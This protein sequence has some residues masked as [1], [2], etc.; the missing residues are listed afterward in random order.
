MRRA[1]TICAVAL[2]MSP[3][4]AAAEDRPTQGGLWSFDESDVVE[5]WEEP[6]QTVRVHYSVMGPNVTRLEDDDDDGVPDYAQD[7]A[8]RT[9]ESIA[10]FT[11]LGFRPPVPESAIETELGGSPAYD[12]YLVDFGGAADGRFGIDGCGN[13]GCAGFYVVENDFAGYGYATVEEGITTVTSHESFHGVQAAYNFL[14]N[15]VS[16]GTATWAERQFD[17]ESADFVRLCNG[18]LADTGRPV[19][20]PPGGPVPL[21]AYGTALWFDFLT[22]RHDVG[23]MV[24]FFEAIADDE[25]AAAPELLFES[26]LAARDDDLERSWATFAQ[27]NLAT[28]PRAGV[29]QSHP[30]ASALDGIEADA[31]GSE[32]AL[33]ARFYPLAASYFNLQHPGGDLWFVTDDVLEDVVFSL[34]PVGDFRPD[35]A[36]GDPIATWTSDDAGSQRI[37]EAL[38]EGG[39]WIVGTL[40]VVADG[41]ARANLCISLDPESSVCPELEDMGT[42]GT[43]GTTGPEPMGTTGEGDDSAG[44]T[45]GDETSTGQFDTDDGLAAEDDDGGCRCHASGRSTTPWLMFGLVLCLRRR[46]P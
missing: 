44:D 16:E 17:P 45:T 38:P 1:G 24:D 7:V 29:A 3:R 18:L 23:L 37:F 6:T 26:L 30:Y 40:A 27:Y 2:W 22:N 12:V 5:S 21:F 19:Y 31:S 9:V 25:N 46:R 28:G 13:E 11:S 42:T 41:P 33:D 43:A 8:E 32:I 20:Q 4:L 39:Y 35:G 15:W 10:L 36:V 34:H 14:P